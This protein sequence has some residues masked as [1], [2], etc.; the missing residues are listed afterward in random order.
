MEVLQQLQEALGEQYR[1]ERELGGGGMA[2]VFVARD[3]TLARQVVIK[4]LSPDL[5]AGLSAKRFEREI[6]LA[7]S[8]QQANIV[9]V[10]SAGEAA[11]VPLYTMPLV[12]G[13]SLRERLAQGDRIP[14]TEAI[15]ILRDVARA[16][17]YAHDR[18]VVHRDI[19]PGNVLLSG[20]TAMVT[21]FG[22]AK[23][24]SAA[25]DG[26][27]S[28]HDASTTYTQAG[29]ALGTPAYMSP[30]QITSDPQMDHRADLYSFGCLAYEVLAGRTPFGDRAAH[31][32]LA[33]HLGEQSVPLGERCPECP[34]VLVRLVMQCL[35]KEAERRPQSAG[36]ILRVLDG[37]TVSSSA[38]S[39]LRNRLSRRQRVGAVVLAAVAVAVAAG[40]LIRQA[41]GPQGGALQMASLGVLPFVNIGGDTSKDLWADGLTDEVTTAL[42]RVRGLRL[43]SRTSVERFRGQRNVNAG[44]AGR[45]LQVSYLVHG[46]F[47]PVGDR[48]RVQAWL[49]R[50]ADDSVV[51]SDTFDHGAEDILATLDSITSGITSAVPP[52]VLGR[53]PSELAAAPGLLRGTSDTAAYE[54]YLRGQVLLRSRGNGVLRAAQLFE[55]AIARDPGFARAHSALSAALTIL[56]NFADTTN[57]E[58]AARATTAARRA[59]DLDPSLAQAEASLALVSMHAFRWA[60]ADSEFR[61]ALTLDPNDAF[62]HMHYGRYLTYVGRLSDAV[63]EFVRAKDLDPTSP[64]IGGW[65][66]ELLSLVGRRSDAFTEIER[67]LEL[68]STSVPI[69]YMGAQIALDRGQTERARALTEIMWRPNGIPRPAPWPAGAALLYAA[70]GDSQMLRQV[71]QYVQTA[72]RSRSFGHSSLAEVALALNDTGR[73]LDE[74]E[75]ATDA[76]EFWPSAPFAA[77]PILDPVRGNPRFA[78]LLRRVGLDVALFTSPRGG[79][80]K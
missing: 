21:D 20:G 80:P 1:I 59:L 30:E 41:R 43:A 45:A 4:V 18:G 6:K 73:A 55:Q 28:P 77:N 78:A 5:A 61:L 24:I 74:F 29:M 76:G 23:A 64:V 46:T 70:I 12:D 56:P 33:S 58:L 72:T 7:A 2:R 37:V 75:R 15:G 51:W 14:L 49:T 52:D 35:E 22:I 39:R 19:K 50:S 38:L 25:R 47:W 3:T 60:E 26:D 9:P 53:A 68:D 40:L 34:P 66:A 32:I 8:L 31:Q 65:L 48:V 36:E 44:E 69:A 62:T 13:L 16:L 63:G 54:L 42:A 79:R 27:E 10:L 17:A 71:A 11:G 67:A 57:Q